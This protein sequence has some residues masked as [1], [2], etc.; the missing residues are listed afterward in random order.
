MQHVH[1]DDLSE[2]LKNIATLI[3]TW[4]Q[5]FILNSKW[6]DIGTVQYDQGGWAHNISAIQALCSD[7]RYTN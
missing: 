6:R 1:P 4:G 2:Y 3:G 7:L 5:A